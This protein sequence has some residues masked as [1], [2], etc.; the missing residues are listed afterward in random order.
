VRLL[1]PIDAAADTLNV[2]HAKRTGGAALKRTGHP[3]VAR[4]LGIMGG[5]VMIAR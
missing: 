1:S 4:S 5:N 2:D 3:L